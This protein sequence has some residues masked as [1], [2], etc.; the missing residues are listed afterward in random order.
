MTDFR[1]DAT[2]TR[3][4]EL[5]QRVETLTDALRTVLDGLADD[6]PRDVRDSP[7]ARGARLAREVLL[8]GGS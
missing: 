4:Q 5:E 8:A 6:P 3:I 1:T 2:E 7:A